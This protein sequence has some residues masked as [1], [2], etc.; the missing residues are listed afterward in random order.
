MIDIGNVFMFSGH[1]VYKN[2]NKIDFMRISTFTVK[3]YDNDAR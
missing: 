3:V 2:S 1:N